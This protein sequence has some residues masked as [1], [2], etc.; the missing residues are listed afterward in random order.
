MKVPKRRRREAKTDYLKRLKLLKS[1]KPRLVFR[2]T[3]RY[4][5]AQYVVSKEAKDKVV[6]G[7]NSKKLLKFKWPEEKKS[8]LKSVPASY[9]TGYLIGK[10]INKQKLE[11]PVID[12]GMLRA[13]HKSKIFAF[14]KGVI[15]AGIKLKYKKEIFP[16]DYRI[17]GE[18]L[19]NK[20][21]FEEIKSNI[22]S[23][24]K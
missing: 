19:K 1:K 12:I 18:H 6:I 20:I 22:D 14:I 7:I 17:K 9:L 10:E 13:L 11:S 5:I 8:S 15:D 21:N 16:E 4:V 23:K 2:K 24:F 3:N